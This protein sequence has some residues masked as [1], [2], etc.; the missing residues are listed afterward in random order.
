MYDQ[1]KLKIIVNDKIHLMGRENNDLYS[2]QII[3]NKNKIIMN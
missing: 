1:S 2:L 3:L